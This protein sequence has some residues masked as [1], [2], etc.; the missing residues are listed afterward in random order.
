MSAVDYAALIP[1]NV[2]LAAD[3][4]LQR[5]LEEWHPRFLDWW[6]NM[7]PDGFLDCEVFLRTAVSVDRE[8]EHNS[9]SSN[10][11]ILLGHSVRA[12]GPDRKLLLV[13]TK[14]P[15]WQDVPGEYRALRALDGDPG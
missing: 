6:A 7:G 14:E 9:G 15:V 11:A 10:A 5:A 4:R 13:H 8:E 3:R 1:N 2:D 12:G